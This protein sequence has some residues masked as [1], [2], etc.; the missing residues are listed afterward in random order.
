MNTTS[1]PAARM[2]AI[3][4][5]REARKAAQEAEARDYQPQVGDGMTMAYPQDM[6]P[7]VITRVSPSGKTVWVKPLELVSK[8]TGHE[9]ARFD[10]PFPVWHHIYTAEERQTMVRDLP[11]IRVNRSRD[12]LRWTA[13]ATPFLRG[14]ACYHR[15]YSY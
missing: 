5:E 4:A 7:Y 15:N 6:Y 14:D 13:G 10:G 8:D 11:E 1:T 9:P 3:R 12:G 2:E